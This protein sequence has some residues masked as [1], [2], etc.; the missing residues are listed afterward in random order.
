MEE[1][2]LGERARTAD[3]DVLHRPE[4][5]VVRHGGCL[6]RRATDSAS[7]AILPRQPG[8]ADF[9]LHSIALP[10]AYEVSW[11]A[12]PEKWPWCRLPGSVRPGRLACARRL[13][14]VPR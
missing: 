12:W 14:W 11:R 10:D 2:A 4:N 13:V 6:M 9:A 5:G 7:P 1:A 8:G 3:E